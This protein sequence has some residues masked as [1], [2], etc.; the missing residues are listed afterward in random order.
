MAVVPNEIEVKDE[1]LLHSS[2]YDPLNDYEYGGKIRNV[3]VISCPR[4]YP[5]Q[6]I[7][8]FF[9]INVF[10]VCHGYNL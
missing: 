9:F 7:K 8:T 5:W 4:L 2:E 3:E 10:M 1:P 6:S